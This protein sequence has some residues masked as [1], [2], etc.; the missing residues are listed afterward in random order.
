MKRLDNRTDGN[1]DIKEVYDQVRKISITPAETDT[2]I[3][4]MYQLMMNQ[5]IKQG[6]NN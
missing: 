4:I 5:M 6:M 2:L 3:R 1:K